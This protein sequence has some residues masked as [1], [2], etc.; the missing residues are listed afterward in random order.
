MLGIVVPLE[1]IN[2]LGPNW[3]HCNSLRSAF[4]LFFLNTKEHKFVFKVYKYEAILTL[5]SNK[6]YDYINSY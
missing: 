3:L 6:A 4:G 1:G 2:T 5:I